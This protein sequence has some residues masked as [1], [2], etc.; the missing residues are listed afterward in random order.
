[1]K[2]FSIGV[3]AIILGFVA[4]NQTK[5]KA[6]VPAITSG[7]GVKLI[8]NSNYVFLDVRTQKEHNAIRIPNTD[9][10]PVHE[11]ASRL[12]EIE[13]YK[14][15]TIILYC[16]SGNRS[17]KATTLLNNAGFDAINLLGGMNQWKGPVHKK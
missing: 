10:I 8:S 5:D 4:W 12:N 1:M 15:K 17:G 9:L 14:D 11:L 7:E 2:L 16:R 13:K 6:G 3:V